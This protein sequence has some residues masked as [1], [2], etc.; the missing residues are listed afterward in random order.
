M[1]HLEGIPTIMEEALEKAREGVATSDIELIG[2]AV[3]ALCEREVAKEN[4]HR[5]RWVKD[6]CGDGNTFI[7]R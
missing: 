4:S 1:A 2:Q 3:V 7:P 5:D 6:P